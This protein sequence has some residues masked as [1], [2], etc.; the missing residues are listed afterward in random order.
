[1]KL[2]AIVGSPNSR[3]VLSVIKHLNLEV[4][5]EYFDLSKGDNQKQEYLDINPNAMV[6]ALVDG[7]FKLWESNAIIQYLADK[8]GDGELFP[9]ALKERAEVVRWQSWELAH[10][11]HAFGLLAFESVAKPNFM[12]T[13]G[14]EGLIL[15]A[16]E[17]LIR[18]AKVLDTH[19]NGREFV[20]GKGLTLADYSLIHVEFFK[21]MIPFDWAVFPH[22]NT[23]FERM[24][25]SPH[26]AATAPKS[27]ELIGKVPQ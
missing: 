7:D 18:F 17:K 6:P 12:G 24:R 13:S 27:P 3:K 4:E 15:W 25:M 22:L 23:Y 1:M 5:L 16:Q 19:M 10:F 21:E 2:Y 26:W 11:N 9:R 20:A 8:A 14:D